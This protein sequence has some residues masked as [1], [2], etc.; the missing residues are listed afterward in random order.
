MARIDGVQIDSVVAAF[1]IGI[2]AFSALFSGLI[3]AFSATTSGRSCPAGRVALCA[4]AASA[5][6]CVGS[7]VSIEVGLT[8]VLLI[9]AG[10]LLRSYERLRSTSVGCI[11]ENVLTMRISLPAARYNTPDQRANFYDAL[12]TRV[13]A[14]PGVE[15]D[16]FSTVVPGQGYCVRSVLSHS[17][18]SSASHWSGHDPPHAFGRAGYFSP[19]G[20]PFT[21]PHFRQQPA[22]RPCR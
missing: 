15:A 16:S 3:S 21:R 12:L 1:T 14:L 9:G 17:R 18:A 5:L 11:T 13:R 19:P 22:S 4:S 8:V 10:L 20:F 6:F 7:L 2:V